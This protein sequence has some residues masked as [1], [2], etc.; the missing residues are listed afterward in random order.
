MDSRE[1]PPALSGRGART[2]EA[3]IRAGRKLFAE[4][5]VDAVAIDDIVQAAAVAKG[6]FYNH[7]PDKEALVRSI[8]DE[9]RAGIE[10]AVDVANDGIEDPARRTVRGI[11]VYL[12]YV[13]DQADRA[14]VL[15]RLQTGLTSVT[16]PLNQGVV[17]DVTAGLAQGRFS[18]ATMEAG[19]LFVMG[20]AQIALVRIAQEPSPA[21]AVALA[22]QLCALLLRGLGLAPAEA[23]A[24]AAQAADDIIR[25]GA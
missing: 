8:I 9:I 12:R 15:V 1:I 5:P 22:Q 20:V 25:G 24:I 10:R 6:S 2:R 19:V 16:A 23:D 3:L 18:L 11:C 14:G 4:R 13:I 17:Q 7:F 21:L